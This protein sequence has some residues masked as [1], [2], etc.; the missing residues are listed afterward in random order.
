MYTRA[1]RRTLAEFARGI[2]VRSA[3]SRDT[4]RVRLFVLVEQRLDALLLLHLRQTRRV[5][6]L[7]ELR[8]VLDQPFRIDDAHLSHVLLRGEHQLVIAQPKMH[9]SMSAADP[10][11]TRSRTIP[12]VDDR[13][14]SRDGCR[15][16]DCRP[17]F[18]S[19]NELVCRPLIGSREGLTFLRVALRSVTEET[20]ADGFLNE[21]G[22]SSARN[23][24]ELVSATNKNGV[25]IFRGTKYIPIHDSQHLLADILRSFQGALL[26]EVLVTPEIGELVLLPR[27][28]NS[29]QGQMVT[30]GLVKAGFALIGLLGFFLHENARFA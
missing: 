21:T 10:V 18:G 15:P 2:V 26:D 1:R 4:P 14:N 22:L 25:E 6:E 27:V 11:T 20:R 12:A 5:A 28:V 30:F 29:Q 23:D 19:L 13:W 16:L 7:E 3:K 24:V 8:R 9:N 17:T